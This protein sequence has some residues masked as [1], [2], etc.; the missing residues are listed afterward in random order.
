MGQ[1]CGPLWALVGRAFVGRATDQVPSSTLVTQALARSEKRV[2]FSDGLSARSFS[3]GAP[4][5]P[6]TA[7]TAAPQSEEQIYI[8]VYI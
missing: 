2:S 1:T 3:Y 5:P 6:A 7:S 4:A 8:D